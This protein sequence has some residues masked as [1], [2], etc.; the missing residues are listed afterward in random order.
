M[1][2]LLVRF[3][4]FLVASGTATAVPNTWI[5]R[6]DGI[7]PVSIGMK[8]SELK[9]KLRIPYSIDRP[10]DSEGQAC[11]YAE[12]SEHPGISLM[13]L[14]GRVARVD[15]DN[16]DTQTREGVHNGQSEASAKAAYGRR[17]KVTPHAYTA[18]EGHYLTLR[19]EDLKYGIRFET[20]NGKIVRYY[21]GTL[22]AISYIEGCE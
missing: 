6:P 13:I 7:G 14:N 8:V 18:P 10:M 11:I 22:E 9:A 21:A 1:P 15:V 12:L 19:S 5:A 16:R 2:Q 17:L 20:D 3:V 4:V